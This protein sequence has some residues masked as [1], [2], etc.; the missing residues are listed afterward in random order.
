M[1]II[2]GVVGRKASIISSEFDQAKN[3][4]VSMS[5][6]MEPLVINPNQRSPCRKCGTGSNELAPSLV[7]ITQVPSH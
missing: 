7:V 4:T 2:V 3:V 5:H 1:V 6:M